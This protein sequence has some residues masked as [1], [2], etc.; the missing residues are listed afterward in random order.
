MNGVILSLRPNNRPNG[1]C[2]ATNQ[3]ISASCSSLALLDET[4]RCVA[5]HYS[6]LY[7]G[8]FLRQVKGGIDVEEAPVVVSV[9]VV[10]SVVLPA[11]SRW[12]FFRGGGSSSKPD[13]FTLWY[14]ND[15][16][17]YGKTS[18][19]STH[20][21]MSSITWRFLQKEKLHFSLVY[22]AKM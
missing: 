9:E 1:I 22:R 8:P 13:T 4:G 18:M 3:P 5:I 11:S 7:V 12:P 15:I 6:E 21:S 2:I 19:F 10:E 16:F 17:R 20:V 14:L